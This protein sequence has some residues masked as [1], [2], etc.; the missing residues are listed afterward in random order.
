MLTTNCRHYVAFV[1]K[2]LPGKSGLSW[3]MFNDEKVVEVEDVQEMKKY[4]YLYFF[5]R[6]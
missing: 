2:A 3:V 6:V 5:S 4:A 1:R